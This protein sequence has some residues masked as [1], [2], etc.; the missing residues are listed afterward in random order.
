MSLP[1]NTDTTNQQLIEPTIDTDAVMAADAA[2][3]AILSDAAKVE[4]NPEHSTLQI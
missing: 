4:L 3:D 1:P 2:A